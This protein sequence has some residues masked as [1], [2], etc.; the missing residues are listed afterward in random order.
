[1]TNATIFENEMLTDAEL[2]KVSAAGVKED[3]KKTVIDK[4][5]DTIKDEIAE[6]TIKKDDNSVPN[7]DLNRY[8]NYVP[9]AP[10]PEDD[11][12]ARTTN[13]TADMTTAYSMMWR[14]MKIVA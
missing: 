3:M 1:M 12:L 5:E 7:R 2:D 8:K 6:K 4:I 11:L 14:R 9:T 13:P 10:G